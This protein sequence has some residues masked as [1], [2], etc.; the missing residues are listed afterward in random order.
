MLKIRITNLY[1]GPPVRGLAIRSVVKADIEK[2]P[3]GELK[4]AS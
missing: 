1:K 3:E 2:E 4:K